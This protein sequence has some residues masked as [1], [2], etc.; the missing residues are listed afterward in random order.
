VDSR[1][2]QYSKVLAQSVYQAGVLARLNEHSPWRHAPPALGERSAAT[3][4]TASEDFQ[5]GQ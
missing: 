3:P 4:G 1:G 5:P 2:R